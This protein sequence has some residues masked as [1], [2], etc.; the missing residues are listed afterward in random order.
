MPALADEISTTPFT[1]GESKTR[2]P[3]VSHQIGQ[4][5]PPPITA[6]EIQSIVEEGMSYAR[7]DADPVRL[8]ARETEEIHEPQI[9]KTEEV[10]RSLVNNKYVNNTPKTLNIIN[11]FSNFLAASIHILPSPQWMKYIVRNAAGLTASSFNFVN[12]FVSGL[13][14]YVSKS[15]LGAIGHLGRALI[16]SLMPQKDQF[17][18]SGF[19]VGTYFMEHVIKHRTGKYKFTNASEYWRHVAN[20]IKSAY[21]DLFTKDLVK[22]FINGGKSMLGF[23]G[24][25]LT[26]TGNAVWLIKGILKRVNILSEQVSN[27]IDKVATLIRDTGGALIDFEQMRPIHLKKAFGNIFVKSGW[28]LFGGTVFDLIARFGIFGML[29]NIKST[30]NEK[31]LIKGTLDLVSRSPDADAENKNMIATFLSHAMD[32]IGIYDLRTYNNMVD[33]AKAA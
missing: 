32:N 2:S 11:I 17:I 24:S 28:E 20:E 19:W 23:S 14:R 9:N 8:A 12:N 5:V 18:G 10:I 16:P 21:K 22:N 30:I 31:G 1:V 4:D 7:P 13:E 33:Q 29:G 15:Y 25:N 27:F 3:V 6:D 26:I